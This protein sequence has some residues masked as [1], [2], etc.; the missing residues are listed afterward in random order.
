MGLGDMITSIVSALIPPHDAT[1]EE[2]YG[3]RLRMGLC[4]IFLFSYLG[5]ATAFA[6][7]IVPGVSGF[8]RASD[9]S[10]VV[11]E[12][13]RN[14]QGD[15]ENRILDLRIKHCDAKTDEAKQLYWSRLNELI[16]G[17]RGLT[18]LPSYPLPACTDL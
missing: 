15:L 14:R 9:L 13:R 1:P 7:G 17:W 18:Q 16:D 3:W 4:V 10:K 2:H 8:A 5:M 6:F 12:I 11:S